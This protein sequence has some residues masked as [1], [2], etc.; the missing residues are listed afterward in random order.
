MINGHST[1]GQIKERPYP[2]KRYVL[3]EDSTTWIPVTW[4]GDLSSPD[5]TYIWNDGSTI[6]QSNGFE[7]YR[8]N[9]D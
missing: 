9:N 7:V 3:P 5:K 1:Y 8:L 4:N 6:F 2:S